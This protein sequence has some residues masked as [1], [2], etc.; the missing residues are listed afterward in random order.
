MGGYFRRGCRK[1]R[2]TNW[3]TNERKSDWYDWPKVI[4]EALHQWLGEAELA[5]AQQGN[6]R[7][8]TVEQMSVR[9][10]K[11]VEMV[12]RALLGTGS[13]TSLIPFEMLRATNTTGFN[14]DSDVEEIM[15]EKSMPTYDASRKEMTLLC[16]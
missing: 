10:V 5:S 8:V 2:I 7:T 11:L 12:R 3:N 4:K 13:K 1:A 9:S 14:F 16:Q 6:R 15:R